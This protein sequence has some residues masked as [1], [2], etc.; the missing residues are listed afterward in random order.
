MGDF[1]QGAEGD[2]AT[3][4]SKATAT[5]PT[6]GTIGF[7]PHTEEIDQIDTIIEDIKGEDSSGSGAGHDRPEAHDKWLRVWAQNVRGMN[8]RDKKPQ[9][10]REIIDYSQ[11]IAVL[12]E[13]KTSIK[14][15]FTGQVIESV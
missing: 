12:S 5:I 3:A 10:V 1:A 4:L 8:S 9:V 13:T 14:S 6:K 11:D 2:G 15:L 7:R